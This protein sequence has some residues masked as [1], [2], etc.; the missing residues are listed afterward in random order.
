MQKVFNVLCYK[1][2]QTSNITQVRE[3]LRRVQHPQLQDTVKAID[4]RS[5][6]DGITYS[7]TYNHLTAAAFKMPDYQ[8][9]R[10]VSSIRSSGGK[11]GGNS[12]VSVPHKVGCSS[13]SIYN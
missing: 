3:L 9:F 10:K 7:V 11:S 5:D 12:G 8:F 6:L 1:G 4:V 13:S 2:V